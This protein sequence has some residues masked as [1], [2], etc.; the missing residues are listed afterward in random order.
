M[1]AWLTIPMVAVTFVIVV[2]RYV[3]SLNWIWMQESVVWMHAALFMLA[4]A[5]TL[6]R[7]EHVRVDIFYRELGAWQK[8]WVDL[9]GTLLF[10]LPVSIFLVVMS[11]DYV[12]V[13]WAIH[14]RSPEAGGMPFPFVPLLKSVIPL[15]FALVAMQGVAMLIDCFAILCRG[16]NA[17][18]S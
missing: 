17:S 14:E 2:L 1:I 7:N 18:E 13:S 3:F 9:G 10:L 5:Y 6:N 15:T 8:A 11:W 12:S 4:S 16:D